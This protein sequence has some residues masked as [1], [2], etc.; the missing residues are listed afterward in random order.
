MNAPVPV[1][2]D[3]LDDLPGA[4]P[5]PLATVEPGKPDIP[6]EVTSE[7]PNRLAAPEPAPMPMPSTTPT[8]HKEEVR[9]NKG[10][11]RITRLKELEANDPILDQLYKTHIAPQLA[12]NKPLVEIVAYLF[13]AVSGVVAA[14][15]MELTLELN[16]DLY[17][18]PMDAQL[19]A[20]Q[21]NWRAR[22][23]AYP[24]TL[25]LDEREAYLALDDDEQAAFRI[26]RDLA[27][28]EK[29]NQPFGVFYLS[30]DELQRRLGGGNGWR[31]RNNFAG[32]Y[33]IIK[34]VKPG[35]LRAKGVRG[36]A[37]YFKWGFPL[38]CPTA[39]PVQPPT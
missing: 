25:S 16:P 3:G 1:G 6:Y 21:D 13:G 2:W 27:M 34:M 35:V 23:D 5:I 10:T 20:L 28:L 18:G 12:G 8:I 38:P 29:D 37:G 36:E 32:L 26:M 14:K 33:R 4:A 31:M 39:E 11:N 30:C 19:T 24:G 15:L 9:G 17:N 22:L 7:S